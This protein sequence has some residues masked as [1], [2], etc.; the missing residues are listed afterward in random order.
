MSVSDRQKIV[1]L[2]VKEILVD[3]ETI[4][5][6]HSI[7]VP[8]FGSTSAT[9]QY[10]NAVK[11]LDRSE[12]AAKAS[13]RAE[14]RLAAENEGIDP[15]LPFS[16]LKA[17]VDGR[18]NKYTQTPSQIAVMVRDLNSFVDSGDE[19]NANI[20]RNYIQKLTMPSGQSIEIGKD[21]RVIFKTGEGA[22][23][24]SSKTSR[25]EAIFK[26]KT[27]IGRLEDVE[28]SID[29][30]TVGAGG[31]LRDLANTI[32][33]AVSGVLG[34]EFTAFDP[35]VAMTKTNL[36]NLQSDLMGYI[37]SDS[38]NMSDRDVRMLQKGI[39]KFSF[40][41]S[42]QQTKTKL[43]EI[44]RILLAKEFF[45]RDELGEVVSLLSERGVDGFADS[46]YAARRLGFSPSRIKSTF[47]ST[48]G[49]YLESQPDLSEEDQ[50]QFAKEAVLSFRRK[51]VLTEGEAL[52]LLYT[53]DVIE[54][55]KG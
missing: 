34:K 32:G 8:E 52:E 14:Y 28:S 33:G 18:L 27:L 40:T 37:R 42:A 41:E 23:T 22:L 5:I 9:T 29:P 51:N 15:N 45:A 17:Q 50:I 25:Q 3:L 31:Y 16:V 19:Q 1:R 7:P 11:D 35:N 55:P 26:A 47:E 43:A 20:I 49:R 46:M 6:K 12:F 24:T 54:Q 53:F 44:K 10:L 2:L 30:S 39:P 4:N 36:D 21:G 38:G 48:V 13:E